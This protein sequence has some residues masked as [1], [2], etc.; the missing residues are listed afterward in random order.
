MTTMLSD[1]ALKDARQPLAPEFVEFL[2]A[3]DGNQVTFRRKSFRTRFASINEDIA[4]FSFE[5]TTERQRELIVPW[6]ESVE[7]ELLRRRIAMDKPE[8]EAVRG[9]KLL[10]S[11]LAYLDLSFGAALVDPSIREIVARR[12][13]EAPSLRDLLEQ[14]PEA[15]IDRTT[16][17]FVD[18]VAIVSHTI[19]G[20][21]N[22]LVLELEYPNR[23][24][25]AILLGAVYFM[26]DRRYLVST[27]HLVLRSNTRS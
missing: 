16:P 15:P 14:T 26:F 20:Y 23:E 7:R 6:S 4:Q 19:D 5:F 22:S 25:Y 17:S 21:G 13:G 18:C 2:A 9:G 27:K 3:V 10:L 24:A 8:D 12:F 11:A 1:R